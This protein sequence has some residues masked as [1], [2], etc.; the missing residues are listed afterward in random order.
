MKRRSYEGKNNPNYGKH[1]EFD[2]EWRKKQKEKNWEKG[3]KS[4]AYTNGSSLKKY[5]CKDC[6]KEISRYSGFHGAGRCNSCNKK[7]WHKTHEPNRN[8]KGSY[9]KDIWMRSS[10]E[11]A[12]A[13][14]LDKNKVKWEYE[15]KVFAISTGESYRPDFYLKDTNTHIEIK[16]Y[17]RGNDKV[18][19]DLFK[20]EYPKEKI[21]LYFKN[22]LNKLGV[23][24]N[25]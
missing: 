11:V 7:D 8:S 20:K 2:E 6:G 24:D 15:S 5:Y 23:Y 18:K 13:T 21:D 14:W 22:D 1:P 17:W 4:H 19:F 9:Y 3:E 16:G 10:Y 12:Y 25:K